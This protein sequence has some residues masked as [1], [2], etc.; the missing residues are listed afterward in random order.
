MPYNI[1]NQPLFLSCEIWTGASSVG[2]ILREIKQRIGDIDISPYVENIESIAI[3]V[4]CF[5]EEMLRDGWGK[6]RKYISYQNKS[7]D[8]RLPIPYVSFVKA[9]DET[10]YRMVVDNILQSLRVI[11]ERCRKS[12]RAKCDSVGLIEELLQRLQVS[13]ESLESFAGVLSE[14]EYQKMV[15]G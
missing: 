14:E 8:I 3:I 2:N 10:K 9:D 4:N 1:T 15:K 12:K 13:H 11:D 5:P 6:P 7:A